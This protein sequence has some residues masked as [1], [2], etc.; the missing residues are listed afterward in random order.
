MNLGQKLTTEQRNARRK[1]PK[2]LAH[3]RMLSD[4]KVGTK[5]S[6][7]RREAIGRIWRG[8][9]HSEETK[10]K[11]SIALSG[12]PRITKGVRNPNKA[13]RGVKNPNWKGGI[14]P[15]HIIIR[16]SIESKIWR[17]AVFERDNYTCVWCG[18]IG[19]NLEADHIQTFSEHPELRFAIDNGR[20]LCVSCHR[21]RH[22]E[23]LP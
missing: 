15:R 23:K 1:N 11:L 5:L 13:M 2:V 17:K 8:K 20:T 3:L 10:K 22:R 16:N 4:R 14:T 19:G 7:E 18:Q 6:P 21:K 9:H 12:K